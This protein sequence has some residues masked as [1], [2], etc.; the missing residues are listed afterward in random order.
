M[1][2]TPTTD[3]LAREYA[4]YVNMGAVKG[5]QAAHAETV[6]T[7]ERDTRL[8]D[9]GKRSELA[10]AYLENKASMDRLRAGFE[11]ETDRATI[12]AGR[13]LFGPGATDPATQ[14]AHRDALDRA[15]KVADEQEGLTQINRAR[16]SGDES[17]VRA[18]TMQAHRKGW[19]SVLSEVEKAAPGTAAKLDQYNS[20]PGKDK[21]A[22][23]L[24]FAVRVPRAFLS[25]ADGMPNYSDIHKWAQK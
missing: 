15:E 2:E 8:T 25:R 10:R 17:M 22:V 13:R 6:T 11:A 24:M 20:I 7:I 12:T 14:L 9:D 4:P 21:K 19:K 5:I 23:D 3:R 16:F 1:A 18:L